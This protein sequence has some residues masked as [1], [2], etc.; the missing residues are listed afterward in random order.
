MI[1]T[2]WFRVWSIIEVET[3]E[4]AYQG[5]QRGQKKGGGR[6]SDLRLSKSKWD[7]KNL[8]KI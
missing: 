4:V 6:Q 1:I 7:E 2:T 8:Y 5:F 3:V